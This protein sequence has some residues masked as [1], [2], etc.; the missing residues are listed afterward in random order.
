MD[1]LPADIEAY[2]ARHTAPE[3][4][5]LA[6]LARDTHIR[7]LYPRMLSG[8]LQGR[9]LSLL[10][11]LIQPKVIVEVG[12]F[13]GYSAI[14]LSEGLHP[15]GGRIITLEADGQYADL[16]AQYFA[17]TP[18]PEVFDLRLG[19]AHQSLEA[20]PAEPHIDLAF[21]DADKESYLDYYQLLVP[22]LRPGG[23][24]LTD[25]VLWSGKVVDKSFADAETEALRHYA[26]FVAGDERVE[27][28]LLPIRD[29]ILCQRK[30]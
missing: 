13:T 24:I 21:I 20:L 6:E 27:A 8:H 4:P 7:T 18:R 14:C 5:L 28:L 22:R 19:D 16:A 9:L 23:L 29:G 1:F 26:T 15:D 2:A 17:R 11:K 3:P 12:T 25:N 10:S 30:R